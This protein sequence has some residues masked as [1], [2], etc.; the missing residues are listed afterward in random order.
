MTVLYTCTHSSDGSRWCETLLPNSKAKHKDRTAQDWLWLFVS[1]WGSQHFP[2]SWHQRY[3]KECGLSGWL[4]ALFVSS[5][6][7]SRQ[8]W[9]VAVSWTLSSHDTAQSCWIDYVIRGN[10]GFAVKLSKHLEVVKIFLEFTQDLDL[11]QIDINEKYVLWNVVHNEFAPKLCI[12]ELL[13]PACRRVIIIVLN[14][15]LF[16]G[17]QE[18]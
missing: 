4:G 1:T 9:H 8:Q 7:V 10:M 2:G 16:A 6:S 14:W 5:S 18:P 15:L 11:Q 12:S 13:K 3:K 17:I